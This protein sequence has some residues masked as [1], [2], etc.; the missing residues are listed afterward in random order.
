MQATA[1]ATTIR[2]GSETPSVPCP[3]YARNPLHLAP[4]RPN[5][6]IS[7]TSRPFPALTPYPP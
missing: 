2:V 5:H 4:R 1:P 3:E 7:S 6:R